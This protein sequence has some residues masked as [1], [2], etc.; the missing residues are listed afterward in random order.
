MIPEHKNKPLAKPI[1]RCM[2]EISADYAMTL[3]KTPNRAK[4]SSPDSNKL[5]K[6]CW[7]AVLPIEAMQVQQ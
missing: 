1:L 2:V 7:K 6:D 5:C 3:Y 4:F